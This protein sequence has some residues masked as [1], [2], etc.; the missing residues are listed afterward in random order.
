MSESR[1]LRERS[2]RGIPGRDVEVAVRTE[3]QP[4]AIVVSGLA[5]AGEHGH[6]GR[7]VSAVEPQSFHPVVGGRGEVDEDPV[8]LPERG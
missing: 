2:V 7:E 8:V 3:G 4:A 1:S 5:Y 6:G